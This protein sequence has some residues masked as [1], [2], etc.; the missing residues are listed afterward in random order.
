MR[1]GTCYLH[2]AH[3]IFFLLFQKKKEESYYMHV[4]Y[5]Y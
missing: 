4:G 1:L 5:L 3:Q 2:K